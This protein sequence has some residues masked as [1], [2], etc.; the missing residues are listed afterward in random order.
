[1]AVVAA[2]A[3]GV[4]GVATAAPAGAAPTEPAGG[5]GDAGRGDLVTAVSPRLLVQ[6]DAVVLGHGPDAP[7]RADSATEPGLYLRRAR[8]GG[9]ATAG[10]FRARVIAEVAARPELPA[11][12]AAPIDADTIAGESGGGAP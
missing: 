10:A 4:S 5:G 12:T 7:A 2:A 8:I 11:P 1:M 9:D 6:A 3:I